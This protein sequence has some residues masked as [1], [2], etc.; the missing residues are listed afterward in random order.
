ML[1]ARN[2]SDTNM[3]QTSTQMCH[4]RAT[5]LCIWRVSE[6]KFQMYGRSKHASCSTPA[7]TAMT[8]DTIARR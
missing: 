3:P 1:G 2:E 7:T 8:S 4:S 6:E 5:M